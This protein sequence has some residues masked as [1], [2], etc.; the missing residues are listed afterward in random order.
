MGSLT[1]LHET[2]GMFGFT[3]MCGSRK[4]KRYQFPHTRFWHRKSWEETEIL[5]PA[6]RR[7]RINVNTYKA[8]TAA[9]D[10][11]ALAVLHKKESKLSKML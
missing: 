5:A 3:S 7:P 11:T 10:V 4:L 6:I 2:V 1:S 9:L 8:C